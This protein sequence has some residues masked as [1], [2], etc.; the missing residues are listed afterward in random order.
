MGFLDTKGEEHIVPTLQKR[1]KSLDRSLAQRKTAPTQVSRKALESTR[2]SEWKKRVGN[3]TLV[4]YDKSLG[5]WSAFVVRP[6]GPV[7]HVWLQGAREALRGTWWGLRLIFEQAASLDKD[8]REDFLEQTQTEALTALES[9]RDELLQPLK[10]DTSES[11]VFVPDGELHEVPLE[12]LALISEGSSSGLVAS[13]WPH[14]AV[15]KAKKVSTSPAA[16]LLH[17]GSPGTRRE[18]R[19]IGSL[20]RRRGFKTRVSSRI[21]AFDKSETRYGVVHAAS[22]GNYHRDRWLLNGIQLAIGWLGFEHLRP[23]NLKGALMYFGSC[24]SGLQNEASGLSLNGWLSAGLGA[25]AAELMLALWKIDDQS[26]SAYAKSFYP[27]WCE[28]SGSAQ[29]AKTAREHVRALHP[30]PFSWAPFLVVA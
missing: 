27:S 30:H 22:H 16:I 13:R 21:E 15:M 5:D 20:L 19:D 14:P 10:L 11:V 29:A 18:A 7:E 1:M 23:A 24:E 8:R 17:N 26:A 2:F 4:I 6:Q 3:R 28:G 9:L 25:G 12:A